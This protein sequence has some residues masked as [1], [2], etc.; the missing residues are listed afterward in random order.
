MEECGNNGQGYGMLVEITT[1][2]VKTLVS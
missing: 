1:G 2:L